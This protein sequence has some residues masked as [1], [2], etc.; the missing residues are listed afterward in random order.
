KGHDIAFN[1]K[2][3]RYLIEFL[4]EKFTKKSDLHYYYSWAGFGA[5]LFKP[6]EKKIAE[7]E[8]HIPKLEKEVNAYLKHR[9]LILPVYHTTAPPHEKLYWEIFSIFKTF[10]KYMPFVAYANA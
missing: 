10:L 6:N 1:G 2:R 7:L 8:E 3:E 5:N 4:K 9:L